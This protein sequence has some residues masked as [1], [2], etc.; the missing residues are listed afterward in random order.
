MHWMNTQGGAG[1]ATGAK[2]ACLWVGVLAAEV[3]AGC[4][5]CSTGRGEGWVEVDGAVS[6]RGGANKIT[7]YWPTTPEEC[8]FICMH[9]G[10][11]KKL[12][13]SHGG[14]G[15]SA[16]H[17]CPLQ[18]RLHLCVCLCVFSIQGNVCVS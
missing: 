9:D 12:M 11:N 4:V 3:T 15:G 13:L 7:L 6:M 18:D 1:G 16:G 17:C 5:V 2:S 14:A 10:G 8:L